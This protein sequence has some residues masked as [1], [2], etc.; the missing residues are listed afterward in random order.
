MAFV[1]YY[2][3]ATFD[4]SEEFD[5]ILILLVYELT[6]G[7]GSRLVAHCEVVLVPVIGLLR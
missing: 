4:L 6:V 2:R 3:N 1:S 7:L 5:S